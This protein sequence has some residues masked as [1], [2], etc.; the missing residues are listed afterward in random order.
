MN[1]ISGPDYVCFGAPS[2]VSHYVNNTPGVGYTWTSDDPAFLNPIIGSSVFLNA[3]QPG[4]FLLTL[5]AIGCG[6]QIVN[7]TCIIDH[8]N[9]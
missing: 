5:T 8:V 4:S 9:I 2:A 3:K 1:E 7:P 6:A